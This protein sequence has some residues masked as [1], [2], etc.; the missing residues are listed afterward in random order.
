MLE[1][2]GYRSYFSNFNF[3]SLSKAWSK[4]SGA[5]FVDTENLQRGLHRMGET[6]ISRGLDEEIPTYIQSLDKEM[7]QEENIPKTREEVFA[8][9]HFEWVK[10]DR[11]G[12]VCNF[13]EFEV[14]NGIEYVAFTDGSRIKMEFVGDI[15]LMHNTPHDILGTQLRVEKSI[16][17][18]LFGDQPSAD[19]S[20][21]ENVIVT[22]PVETQVK[23]ID[24]V[25]SILEKGKKKL[26]KL[27]LTINVKI[28][29]SELYNVIKENFDNTDDVLLDNV[30]DQIQG[31]ML[32]DA[33]KRELQTLYSKKKKN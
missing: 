29:S 19:P 7:T 26:E 17:E 31:S 8:E 30:M 1:G 20:P 2:K 9:S 15:V 32:R 6:G 11:S 16:E 24:P 33:V 18:V 10:T 22:R 25:I 28:P 5:F 3:D 23:S 4:L 27:N 21:V 13:K 12:D 14:E